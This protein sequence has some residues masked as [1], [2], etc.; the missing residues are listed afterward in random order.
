MDNP[1][2]KPFKSL[3]TMSKGKK[4]NCANQMHYNE[5]ASLLLLSK[6]ANFLFRL[7]VYT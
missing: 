3:K 2:Q 6:L 5:V 4:I 1:Q 7:R